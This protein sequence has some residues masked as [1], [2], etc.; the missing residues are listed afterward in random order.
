MAGRPALKFCL[1]L[2]AGILGGWSAPLSPLFLLWLCAALVITVSAA[3][4]IVRHRDGPA[5]FLLPALIVSFGVL[6]VTM[7]LRTL[8]SGDPV[9][10][11]SRDTVTIGGTIGDVIN[12]GAG[13]PRSIRFQLDCSSITGGDTTSALEGRILVMLSGRAADSSLA[14]ALVPGRRVSVRGQVRPIDPPGNPGE[15]DWQA[16]YRLAGIGA[17]MSIRAPGQVVPGGISGEGFTNRF[18][19]PVRRNLSERLLSYVP[20]REARFLN[21]L[22]LGER[23]EVPSDLKSDFITVGVMHLLA[24]SGQQVVLVALLIAGILTVLRVPEKPRLLVVACALAYYVALTGAS[25][26]VTRAGIMSIVVLGSGLAQRRP[27]VLNALGV[28]ASGILLWDPKQLFDPGFL[29]S[30]SAVLAIVLLYPVVLR[31]TPRLTAGAARVRILDLAWKGVAVSLAAGLGTAPIVAYYFGRVSLVGFLA[32]I[33]IVPLS[34]VALVLGMLTVGAS[35]AWGWLASVYG[36]AAEASAWLT[37]A[38]VDF[39]ASF[40]YASVDFRMSLGVVAAVYLFIAILIASPPGGTLKP[41]LFGLLLVSNA[42]LYWK[43]FTPQRAD[44]LRVTFLDVGQGDAAFVEFPGGTTMLIDAGPRSGA[45]D[46]GE[47]IVVPFLRHLDV[48]RIDYL[49]VSHPHGDHIGGAPA[50]MRAFPVGTV[51]EGGG[52]GGG[53]IYAEFERLADS[54]GLRRSVNFAGDVIGGG[55]PVR[56]YVVSPERDSRGV[57]PRLNDASVALKL[58]YGRTSVLFPGDAEAEAE[59]GM[60][61]RYGVW[62][63]S[64][65]LKAGHHGSGTSSTPGFLSMVTPGHTIISAGEG[66]SFGHPAGPVLDRLRGLA[67]TIDRTDLEGAAVYE[68]DGTSWR[69]VGRDE[70]R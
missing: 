4:I 45:F 22:L 21:G 49:V 56:T 26:S 61:A 52:R 70:W 6:L 7:D 50:V 8:P 19:L 30:F 43:A 23:N 13:S 20:D 15:I 48:R 32:N 54:L 25:P 12:R 16:H 69:R 9:R 37:F 24:I 38:L 39:F 64:D 35:F 17:R 57:T 59:A 42:A 67:S 14:A 65:L 36:A 29:L 31:L 62:L 66:N 47:R 60:V 2:A 40:P 58:A 55:S 11:I 3:L 63:D 1:L 41:L 34:S 5:A 46:A 44:L 51:I 53:S 27:D 28:A 18:V 33:L 68:S 10:H